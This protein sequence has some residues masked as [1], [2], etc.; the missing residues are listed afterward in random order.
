[1]SAESIVFQLANQNIKTEINRTIILSLVLYGCETWS[2]IL[3]EERRLRVFENRV[4]RKIFRR[5]TDEVTGEWRRLHSEKLNDVYTSTSI[6]RGIR[7][8]R[9]RW[10]GRLALMRERRA[11]Y[12][13]FVR[14]PERKRPLGRPR[15]RRE[16]NIK[17]ELHDVG[18]RAWTGLTWL[19][20]DTG[21]GFCECGEEH[22]SSVKCG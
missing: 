11:A 14:K 19:K 8:R 5:K 1:L 17:M 9:M 10:E 4:L 2:L 20:I 22:S 21:S 3:R 13:V 16:D 15:N 12:M 7:S 6:S 18:W